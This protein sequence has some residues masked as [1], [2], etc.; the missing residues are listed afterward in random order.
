MPWEPFRTAWL[1]VWSSGGVLS[2]HL[3]EVE[4]HAVLAGIAH[5]VKHVGFRKDHVSRFYLGGGA[6]EE[7]LP[8]ALTH[9]HDLF[10]GM[11]MR[12][13]RLR[14]RLQGYEARGKRGE[15]LC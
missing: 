14:S 10:F 12:R 11:A 1:P 13:M 2:H 3:D 9:D 5:T 15:L 7:K 8:R 4:R 6:I